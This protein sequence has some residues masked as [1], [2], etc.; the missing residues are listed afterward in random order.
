ME[1]KTPLTFKEIELAFRRAVLEKRDEY[2]TYASIMFERMKGQLNHSKNYYFNKEEQIAVLTS[3]LIKTRDFLL[4][5]DKLEITYLLSLNQPEDVINTISSIEATEFNMAYSQ[6]FKSTYGLNDEELE[7]AFNKMQNANE[8]NSLL[9]I[10]VIMVLAQQKYFDFLKKELQIAGR[11][12]TNNF[13]EQI[14]SKP[15]VKWNRPK[16]DFY[17]L[18]Y[19]LFHSNAIANNTVEI[20]KAIEGLAVVFDV[21]LAKNWQSG[22]SKSKDFSNSNADSTKL[23]DDLA[24]GYLD[25]VEGL[26]KKKRN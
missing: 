23:F 21:E 16:S 4:T 25:Y 15:V 8:L 11:K 22:S 7:L 12:I 18:V 13:I 14:N 5:T 1:K 17:R 9:G 26:D 24:K 19:G 2:D 3:E 10:D 6:L 20:T